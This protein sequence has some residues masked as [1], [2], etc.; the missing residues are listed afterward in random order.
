MPSGDEFRRFREVRIVPASDRALLVVFDDAISAE[1]GEAVRS[2]AAWLAGEPIEGVVDWHPAYG[3]VLVESDPARISLPQLEHELR[4][5]ALRLPSHDAPPARSHAL[6]VRYG[7][8]DG[9]DLAGVATMLGLSMERVVE[10]HSASDYEVRFLGFA[11]GFPYLAGLPEG[12][13]TPRREAPRR[14]V[15]PGS[16]AIAGE[17]AGI[18][19]LA[20]PG[21]WNLIGRTS[22]VIFD[23]RRDPPALLSPGDRVRFIVDEGAR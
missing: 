20:T 4:R 3:S 2:L 14:L 5:R 9:P 17:Q 15:S 22:A 13:R 6:R 21:G 1:G 8:D 12:L 11:P 7:G 10:L 23:P 18:Y 16:V 19:A